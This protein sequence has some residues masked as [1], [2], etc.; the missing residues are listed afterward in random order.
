[1]KLRYNENFSKSKNQVESIKNCL[2][3][4][5][6][7]DRVY[8]PKKEGSEQS[9]YKYKLSANINLKTS[10]G[11]KVVLKIWLTTNKTM[12]P[13]EIIQSYK[14]RWL[15]EIFFREGKNACHLDDLPSRNL[16]AIETYLYFKL[17]AYVII[18]VFKQALTPEYQNAGIKIL[19]R[20]FFLK[21]GFIEIIDDSLKVEFHTSKYRQHINDQMANIDAYLTN[22]CVG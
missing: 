10:E 19:K 16:K 13:L 21:L 14:K 22:I 6:Q 12:T 7:L 17:F 4:I 18:C 1:M 2:D 9:V 11:K 5:N 8:T 3:K 15:I 20:C